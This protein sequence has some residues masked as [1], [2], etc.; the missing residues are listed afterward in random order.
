M[1][2]VK[3]SID[4]AS[5]NDHAVLRQVL[6]SRHVSHDQLYQ[7]LQLSGHRWPRRTLNWRLQRLVEHRLIVRSDL[8][9]VPGVRVYA[10]SDRGASYLIGK[11]ESAAMMIGSRANHID[12]NAV[13]HSLD[14]NEIHLSVLRTQELVSWKCELE[15]RSQNEFTGAGFA[16]DYDA[17]ITVNTGGRDVQ[18]ALEYERKPKQPKRYWQIRDLIEKETH[19]ECVLYLTSNFHLL[20][21]VSRFFERS[22][23]A[24][25]FGVL[26]EFRL[27]AFETKVMDSRRLVTFPL[28]SA[29]Q[30]NSR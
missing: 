1:R 14:I 23:K 10:L 5:V 25:Y 24:V 28:V 7:F 27:H 16:K 21:Y 30:G 6:R 4:L 29:L 8:S 15:I 17:I 26:D 11:G 13:Q 22:A 12:E 18:F 3:G 2:Y 9:F 20:S 19:V